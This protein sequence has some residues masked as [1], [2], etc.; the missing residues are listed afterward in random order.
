MEQI[1][2]KELNKIPIPDGLEERLSAKIDEWEREEQLNTGSEQ[3]AAR[4]RYKRFRPTGW[5]AI[6]ASLII[7]CGV[8]IAFYEQSQTSASRTDTFQDPQLAY[9]EAEKAI[10][11]IAQTINSGMNHYEEVNAKGRKA[12]ETFYNSMNN[13]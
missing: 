1:D 12:E 2:I 5:V 7:T 10:T 3:T 4:Q 11:L 6:A 8:S 13:Y 9:Q